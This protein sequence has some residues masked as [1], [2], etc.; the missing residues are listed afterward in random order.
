MPLIGMI[1]D[2]AGKYSGQEHEAKGEKPNS[3]FRILSHAFSPGEPQC[4]CA[5]VEQKSARLSF[6]GTHPSWVPCAS[7]SGS[8]LL[9]QEGTPSRGGTCLGRPL[10]D[11]ARGVAG[12]GRLG[13]ELA[14]Q[15][16]PGNGSA[17]WLRALGFMVMGLVWGLSLAS[18][19]DT[20]AFLVACASLSQDGL[21]P[22]G[23]RG[24]GRTYRLV[25]F[26]SF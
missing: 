5:T 4:G 9:L 2:L 22:E 20:G 1:S 26:H 19:S 21:H 7:H 18:R 25:S 15:G 3:G 8:S 23:F 11:K 17:S 14:G 12:K 24:V 6:P 13:G 16:V 10:A